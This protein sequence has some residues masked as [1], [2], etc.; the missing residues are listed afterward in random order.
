MSNGT[1]VEEWYSAKKRETKKSF[2]KEK[3]LNDLYI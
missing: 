1:S 2:L 3:R